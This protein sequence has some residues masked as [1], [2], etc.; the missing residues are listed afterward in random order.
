MWTHPQDSLI[1]VGEVQ[2]ADVFVLLCCHAKAKGEDLPKGTGLS[3]AQSLVP[4]AS[5]SQSGA[6]V[7]AI[8]PTLNSPID[9]KPT[10]ILIQP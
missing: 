9:P 2:C 1:Q 10:L 7:N 4:T 6:E 3:S 8:M 5:Q